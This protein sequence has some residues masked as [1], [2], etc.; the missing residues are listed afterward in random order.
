LAEIHLAEWKLFGYKCNMSK[1]VNRCKVIERQ[2]YNRER[3][4]DKKSLSAYWEMRN[5][6]GRELY[7][8]CCKLSDRYAIAWFRL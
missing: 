8:A 6:W 3:M 5:K 2:I 4:G 1:I 7:T